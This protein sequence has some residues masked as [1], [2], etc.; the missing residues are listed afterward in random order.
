MTVKIITGDCRE[1]LA[2]MASESVHMCVTSPPYWG[3]RDYGIAGQI[4]LEQ[5]PDAYVAEMVAVFRE[6]RRVL[7]ADGVLF[8]NLGDSYFGGGRGGGGSFEKERRAWR[9]VPC[10]SFTAALLK[11]KDLVGIPWRVAFALQADGWWLRQDIIWSKPNPM[12]ESITDR[13]TKAHE[14]LFLL[15][16]SER[17]YYDVEAIKEPASEN[18]H[19]RG[20]GI[21]VKNATIKPRGRVLYNKDYAAKINGHVTSRNKRSVWT[22]ASAPFSEA[23][24]AT[25]PPALVEPCILAGTSEKGCCAKC[26]M[27]WV[28]DVS[29][30]E[31]NKITTRG[32]Q[33]WTAAGVGQRQRD[34][35]GSL[36]FR[37][38]ETIG[39]SPSCKCDAGI[40]PCTVLDPFGGAGTTALVADRLRRGAV[41]IE[42]NPEYAAMAE[43]RIANDSPLFNHTYTGPNWEKELAAARLALASP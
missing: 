26:G 13:C 31:P 3:L 33:P 25:F 7:R 24:F 32:Q 29:V 35:R 36:P 41:L 43:R 38:R 6:V 37:Q 18:T 11:P 10:E 8:L 40:V 17:Y 5:S 39:W 4:G 2:L 23:H 27:P 42:L 21:G 9:D 1:A 28:R 20:S 15:T 16:K 12:P 14:Y 34:S 30:S 22:I 19:S